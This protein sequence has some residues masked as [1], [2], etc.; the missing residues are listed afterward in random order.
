MKQR[1]SAVIFRDRARQIQ[2]LG[3]TGLLAQ[4]KPLALLALLVL[5]TPQRS[6]ATRA[7]PTAAVLAARDDAASRNAL[8]PRTL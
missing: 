6:D 8:H 3:A 5:A 4:P 2:V 1:E 7:R